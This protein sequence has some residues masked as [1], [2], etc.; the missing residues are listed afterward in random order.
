M[1]EV[2]KG[3]NDRP[4]GYFGLDPMQFLKGKSD[5]EIKRMELRE[6]LN[7]R[8]AM[9]GILGMF[10]SEFVHDGQVLAETSIF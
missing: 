8:L 2:S 9:L 10:A 1:G 5:A 6:L 4:A 7:G 3:E